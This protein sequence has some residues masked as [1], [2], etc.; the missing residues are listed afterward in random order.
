MGRQAAR[1]TRHEMETLVSIIDAHIHFAGDTPESLAVLDELDAK[2]LNVCVAADATGQWRRQADVYRRLASEHPR[3]YAWCTSFDPP[4]G[5]EPGY[6]DRVIRCLDA[7]F[8]AGAVA[9]KVWRNIGMDC[10]DAAGRL[11][12]VDDPRFEPIFRYLEQAGRTLLMHIGEPRAAWLPLE[13]NPYRNA[14]IQ[15]PQYH[16]YHRRGELPTYAELIGS[17]DRVIERHPRLRIVGAHL[18]S[19]DHDVAEIARRFDRYPNFAVDTSARLYGLSMQDRQAVRRFFIDYQDRILFGTDVDIEQPQSTMPPEEQC[20]SRQTLH[21]AF[22]TATAFFGSDE[23]VAI[24]ERRVQ[25]LA[26]PAEVMAKLCRD[27]ASR[28]YPAMAVD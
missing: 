16:L 4:A 17:R 25:G 2:L 27:N 6:A 9:C 24:R 13:S 7:D 1:A 10:R 14:Y 26:L 12:M 15:F 8:A 22:Q 20:R 11:I 21:E 3:R 19:M 5:D 18:G 23:V 28:W